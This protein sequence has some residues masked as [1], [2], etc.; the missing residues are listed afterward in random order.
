MVFGK[1][2]EAAADCKQAEDACSKLKQ[3]IGNETLSRYV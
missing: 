2:L 1:F 3:T